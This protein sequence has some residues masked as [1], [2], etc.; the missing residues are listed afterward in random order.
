M[1]RFTLVNS[2]RPPI[3]PS[4]PGRPLAPARGCASQTSAGRYGFARVG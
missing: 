2:A 4:N 1:N 3:A